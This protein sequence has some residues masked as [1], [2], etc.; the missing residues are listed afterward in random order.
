M[1]CVKGTAGYIAN[2]KKRAIIKTSIQFGIVLVLLVLGYVQTNTKLN[3]L[4]VV[5]I[6]GCLPASKSLVE[7]IMTLPHKTIESEL[8][9]KIEAASAS[10]TL[11]YD[12]VLTSEKKIMP[13]DCVVI[14]NNTVCGYSS[15]K[16]IDVSFAEKHIK[17]YLNAN[18]CSDASV[19]IFAEETAFL[20]RAKEMNAHATQRKEET[21]KKEEAIR[22]VIINISL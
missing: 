11:V 4:T 5:A 14:S 2:H 17:Q 1:K 7:V 16:K 15:S 21:V 6:V 8:V 3:M 13:I 20:K 12:L 9:K 19:K 10:L 18:Q 22:S